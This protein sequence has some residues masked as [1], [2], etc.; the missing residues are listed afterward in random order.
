M[1][2]IKIIPYDKDLFEEFPDSK[3]ATW[4]DGGIAYKTKKGR[5]YLLWIDERELIESLDI[6]HNDFISLNDLVRLYIF[7]S[8]KERDKYIASLKLLKKGKLEKK[9]PFWERIFSRIFK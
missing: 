6:D 3:I 9:K 2:M 5:K 8:E 1:L 7:D 4:W